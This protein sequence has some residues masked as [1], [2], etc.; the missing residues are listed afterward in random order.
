[1]KLI[2][3][4]AKI[5]DSKSPF[6]NKTVDILIVDGFIKK[7]GTS[8]SNSENIE[9][10]KLDNLHVSQGWFDSSVSLGEPGFE[11]RE[12]TSNGLN[13]AAKSGFTAIALQPNSFPIIDNQ[14]QVNFVKN[15]ATGF[16]TQLYPIGALT[17]ESQGK[18]MAELY[19]MQKAGAIAFGDYN[20]SLSN[21][22][23]L[24]IA[25][26]YVQDF[27]GLTIAF[28][29]DENIKGNGVAN[30]GVVSTSLGLKGIPNL[31]EEL[32][33]ARNLFLLEYTGGKLHI[34][35][36]STK[37]SVQLIKE[38]KAN[39]LN[40]S[41]SVAVHH[42]VLN[43]EKLE[44][45]DTRYKIS[46]PLRTENDRKALLK[47]IKDGTIDMIT[48]D[49]NPIDIEHKKMEFDGAKSGTIGLESA[50]GALM[51]VLPL[52]IIIEKLTAGKETFGIEIQ[53][54]NEGSKANITLFNP[55][56]KSVFTKSLI[57]SKSKNSAFLGI[58][59]QGKVHGIVNQGQLI[60]A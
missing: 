37:K 32:Q 36:V 10:I 3:R 8:L 35:T 19:D 49:H 23:L 20:K 15:K 50:F 1:M 13:V 59:I 28:S 39:G 57:L 54:I 55:E 7:I 47:G 14:S 42:L 9:E 33:I 34:P 22:N 44:G 25:L 60:L 4:D 27:D 21:A 26:Q 18:D 53:T 12:T 46:P 45:F 5:I 29:Q 16:A 38:A 17:K 11:D 41:C 2:I 30:E 48:S 52:E 43:D 56:P 58:E 6:N 51:T 24:K 31:A 40:V